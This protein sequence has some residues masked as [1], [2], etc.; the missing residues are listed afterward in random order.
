MAKR[1]PADFSPSNP[2][3]PI[4]REALA[5][6]SLVRRFAAAVGHHNVLAEAERQARFE[7]VFSGLQPGADLW[8]F[9]YGSMLWNPTVHYVESRCVRVSGWHRSFCLRSAAGRGSAEH[10]GLMLGVEPGGECEGLAYRLAPEQ[11]RA[12]LHLLW[13]REMVTGAYQARWLKARC[14]ADTEID[15]IVFVIDPSG[16]QYEGGLPQAEQARRI[17]SAAGILGSNSDYLLRTRFH[18]RNH[19]IHDDYIERLAAEVEQISSHTPPI[20]R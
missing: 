15:L 6:G 8:L 17:Q 7:A 16:S 1:T 4:S 3:T 18:L 2:P 20:S 19:G 12:E 11:A 5:D 13:Q 14:R 9:A 10:P